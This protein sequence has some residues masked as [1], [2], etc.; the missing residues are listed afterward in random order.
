[1]IEELARIAQERERIGEMRQLIMGALGAAQTQKAVGQ[2]GRI[3]P[4]LHYVLLS[5]PSSIARSRGSAGAAGASAS[6]SCEIVR[7]V[8][9]AKRRSAL[10]PLKMRGPGGRLSRAGARCPASH[11]GGFLQ[12]ATSHMHHLSGKIWFM[13]FQLKNPKACQGRGSETPNRPAIDPRAPRSL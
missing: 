5:R 3:D 10:T 11:L 7:R 9:H 4:A 1:M 8:A 6:P 12:P 2:N 13:F